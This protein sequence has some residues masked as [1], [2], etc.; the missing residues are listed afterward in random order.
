MNSL[1]TMRKTPEDPLRVYLDSSDYSTLSSLPTSA[2]H[3]LDILAQLKRWVADGAITCHFSGT[4][5]SEMAP[6]KS[7]D[8][9]NSK[10]CS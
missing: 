3:E 4:H 10:H 5:L 7:K 6:M 1:A 9:S 8:G 2:E